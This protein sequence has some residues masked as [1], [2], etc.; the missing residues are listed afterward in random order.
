[1]VACLSWLKIVRNVV[2]PVLC[3]L[4]KQRRN[5]KQSSLYVPLS[6]D[7]SEHSSNRS[8]FKSLPNQFSFGQ[9]LTQKKYAS[10]SCLWSCATCELIYLLC[11]TSIKK[12]NSCDQKIENVNISV[13]FSFLLLNN[14]CCGCYLFIHFLSELWLFWKST[15]LVLLDNIILLNRIASRETSRILYAKVSRS[16][17]FCI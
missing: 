12:K 4:D 10:I 7:P 9:K 1:M 11:V 15:N 16:A 6:A 13:S 17:W 8:K 14:F 2:D 3:F 5:S